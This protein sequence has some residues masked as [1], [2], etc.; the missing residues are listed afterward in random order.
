MYLQ[1]ISGSGFK[2]VMKRVAKGATDIVKQT[3][4][5]GEKVFKEDIKPVLKKEAIKFLHDTVRPAVDKQMK[6]GRENLE[7]RVEDTL[8]SKLGPEYKNLVQDV[9]TETSANLSKKASNELD[10]LENNLDEAMQGMGLMKNKDYVIQGGMIMVQGS[11]I[12]KKI[13]RGLKKIGKAIAPVVKPVLKELATQGVASLGTALTGN[14]AVGQMGAEAL[15]GLTDKGVD[16]LYDK[17]TEGAGVLT[18]GKTRL[19]KSNGGALYVPTSRGRGLVNKHQGG[20]YY[21]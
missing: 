18:T 21:I 12:G 17:A 1:M 5:A 13:L 20:K 4:K 14:P 9:V 7:M 6:K 8:I 15:S 11:D 19:K 3:R 16:K 2:S 10:R